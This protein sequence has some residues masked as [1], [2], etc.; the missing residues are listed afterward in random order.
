MQPLPTVNPFRL[1]FRGS[2]SA[3]VWSLYGKVV[4]HRKLLERRFRHSFNLKG[5]YLCLGIRGRLRKI[6][7]WL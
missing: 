6:I 5:R 3:V 1:N 2:V 7:E 4:T